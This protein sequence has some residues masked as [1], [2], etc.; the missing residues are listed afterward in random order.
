MNIPISANRSNFAFP[1]L[2]IGGLIRYIHLIMLAA[3]TYRR[4]FAALPALLLA[5]AAPHAATA[6]ETTAFAFL[7][8]DVGARADVVPEECE[9][10]RFLSRGGMRRRE[11]EKQRRQCGENPPVCECGE[12]YQVNVSN[13]ASNIKKGKS[14]IASVGGNRYIHGQ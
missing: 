14:E 12:H 9:R 8:N 10:G 5:L 7:R 13:Q 1:L 11:R 6:Q 4:I 3:L 2:D